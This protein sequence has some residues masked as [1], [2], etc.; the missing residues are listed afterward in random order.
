MV[1]KTQK[2]YFVVFQQVGEQ[3]VKVMCA[4]EDEDVAR[5]F[6]E[7]YHLTYKKESA[8]KEVDENKEYEDIAKLLFG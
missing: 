6:C 3:T 4:V 5:D 2:D 7:K 1:Y 8:I